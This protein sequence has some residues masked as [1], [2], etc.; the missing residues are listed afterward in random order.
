MKR[1]VSLTLGLFLVLGFMITSAESQPI[2]LKAVTAFP[3]NHLNNDPV[4]LFVDKVNKRSEGKLKIEWVGGP[5][6]IKSFDQILAVK[7][8]TIDMLLYYPFGYMKPVMP[9]AWAKGLTELAE[10]EERKSGAFQLWGEIFEKRVNAK[11]LGRLHNLLPFKVFCN[12][13]IEKVDDFKGMKI[14]VMP[15]YI[16]FMKALGA[17]PVTISPDEIYTSMERGVVDGFMWP[18]VGVISWGLQEVT[19]YVIDPGVF[20]MEPATMINMDKWK[21]IPKDTQVLLD[22]IMQDM[23]YIASM[24]NALIE[25]KEDRVRKKAGMKTLELPP[26]EAEKFVK[27]CYDKTWEFVIESA[28]EYG[29]KLRELSSKKAVPPNTFPWQ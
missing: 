29:P 14:R 7:S 1:I 10:W 12:K 23:E 26:A 17:T 24:R 18:N 11:Y 8:G 9:E 6:V 13:K 27:I 2:V 22:E 21:K 3:K 16:P 15:L 20:Q 19:K 28:P 4:P 25:A 5:E